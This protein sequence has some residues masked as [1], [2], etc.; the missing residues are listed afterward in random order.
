MKKKITNE[1]MVKALFYAF[2][3]SEGRYSAIPDCCIEEYSAG[4]YYTK[5]KETLSEKDQKKLDKW[6]YVPCNKC[7]KKNNLVKIKNNGTS[8]HGRVIMSLIDDML[9]R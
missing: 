4:K 3:W 2:D 5:F 1:E 6:N 9:D 8:L 7:F